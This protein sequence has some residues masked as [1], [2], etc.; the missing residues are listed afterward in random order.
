LNNNTSQSATIYS[1]HSKLTF[2]ASFAH[3]QP[4]FSTKS[5][6]FTLSAF[7]KPFSKSVCITHAACGA[8]S[9]LLIVHALTSCTHAV[10]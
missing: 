7:I 6:Q 5:F 10:K 2:Q 8:E 1:F 9:H 4:L 3:D